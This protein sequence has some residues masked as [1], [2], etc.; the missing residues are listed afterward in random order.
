MAT[1]DFN[2][3]SDPDIVTV[4][5]ESKNFSV[6]ISDGNG[7]F[8]VNSGLVATVGENPRP[9][10]IAVS[11]LNRDGHLDMIAAIKSS[12]SVSLYVVA[13]IGDGKGNFESRTLF[14]TVADI[15]SLHVAD[16]SQDGLPDIV[17]AGSGDVLIS[18]ANRDGSCANPTRT[19]P[20]LGNSCCRGDQK[21]GKSSC[22]Y[23]PPWSTK[24]IKLSGVV[25]TS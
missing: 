20:K 18:L 23:T 24:F 12:S 21:L 5:G 16:I 25:Q 4:N 15:D 14:S 6:F 19:V 22:R 17:V 8:Q 9:Y 11:D 10:E 3:D 13:F 7:G 1:G 2:E